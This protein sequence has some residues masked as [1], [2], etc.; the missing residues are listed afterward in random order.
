MG[1]GFCGVCLLGLNY[2][3]LLNLAPQTPYLIRTRI[4]FSPLKKG[5]AFSL[6]RVFGF[7]EIFHSLALKGVENDS[8][9]FINEE[10]ETYPL[11]LGKVSVW[12]VY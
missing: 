1:K 5:K 8:Y 7:C 9:F 2:Q 4:K 12:F 6:L 11:G 10:I 3:L